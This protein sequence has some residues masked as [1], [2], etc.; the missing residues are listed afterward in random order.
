MQF[1]ESISATNSVPW[2]VGTPLDPA[3]FASIRRRAILEHC[4][5]DPQVGDVSTL[6]PFPLV[7]E[8]RTWRTLQ[9]LAEQLTVEALSAEQEILSRPALLDR[10]GLP[11]ALRKALF[12]APAFTPTAARVM[13]FDF[14]FTTKGWLISEV[15]SDVP[16][17]FTEAS[18]FTQ[19]M[20][21]QFPETVV[22]GN[23]IEQWAD[24]IAASADGN[25][26]I[27]LL[28]APGYMEDHQI[29]SYVAKHLRQRKCHVQLANPQQI[30]W[31]NGE[32]HLDTVW[33]RGRL[34]AIVRFYQGE[35]L[36]RLSDACG[37][38][39]FFSGG[40][41]PVANP[42]TAII[43]ET[44]RFPLVW[45][46]LKTQLPT[47]R[48]L[49]PET[50]DPRDAP[51]E[52]DDS[53]LVKSSLCNT[54]DT[55]SVRSALDAQ[56]WKEVVRDVHRRPDEWLAQKRFEPIWFETP[57]GPQHCC[58]GVYTINGIAAGAYTRMTN[59]VCIDFSATDVPLLVTRENKNE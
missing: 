3:T 50:R 51:W 4:K 40:N 28:S 5:W 12:F 47:W 43:P 29:V 1:T 57:Q 20:Q 26:C 19:M 30:E 22:P 25:G 44:K 45:D 37:W 23:P 18:S 54:G 48:K 10:L 38:N 31:R 42:G 2:H 14:H 24:A 15:N 16:G 6:A 17:G 58:I 53:W 46:Q 39:H 33:H 21:E 36:S 49:L 59:R 13:R 9:T 41:T 55:V 8:S 7:I 34:D 11:K 32:A 27:A 35:W 52:A 56:K